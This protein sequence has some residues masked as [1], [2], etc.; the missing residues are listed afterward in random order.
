MGVG[1]PGGACVAP[2][3]REA[4][5]RPTSR[6]E[7]MRPRFRVP[8]DEARTPVHLEAAGA[9]LARKHTVF[10]RRPGRGA[11]EST[12]LALVVR[13]AEGRTPL[14]IRREWAQLSSGPWK[15]TMRVRNATGHPPGAPTPTAGSVRWSLRVARRQVDSAVFV[16]RSVLTTLHAG[17]DAT[18][19]G[20]VGERTGLWEDQCPAWAY[21]HWRLR[22]TSR[23]CTVGRERRCCRR[24]AHKEESS[25]HVGIVKSQ[26]PI[27][28][29]FREDDRGVLELVQLQFS[30]DAAASDRRCSLEKFVIVAE[31]GSPPRCFSA[32]ILPPICF[33]FT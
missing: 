27:E 6:H 16:F 24:A 29:R 10:F 33:N 2:G 21:S 11:T 18:L 7:M 20:W 17:R 13:A 4:D 14:R 5:H 28:L 19:S 12:G 22:A 32:A 3:R 26:R 8:D 23:P 9:R 30:D 15:Q 1:T 31:A 25:P